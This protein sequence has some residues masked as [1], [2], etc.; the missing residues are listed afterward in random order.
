M[1]QE[2][3]QLLSRG[4]FFAQES[5]FKSHVKELSIGDIRREYRRGVKL[6]PLLDWLVSMALPANAE[7]EELMRQLDVDVHAYVNDNLIVVVNK[8]WHALSIE[9]RHVPALDRL[10]DGMWALYIDTMT[11]P[12]EHTTPFTPN[13]ARADALESFRFTLWNHLLA[14][15]VARSTVSDDT[16]NTFR[17][18][19]SF[20]NTMLH[21]ARSVFESRALYE[22]LPIDT[23]FVGRS[24]W[25]TYLNLWG[26]PFSY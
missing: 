12:F 21:F 9:Y 14:I 15:D 11:H 23:P 24:L 18:R 16:R 4:A 8:L 22:P 2:E 7:E 20:L 5:R 1:Q 25:A 6:G 26:I 10:M 3:Q 19:T 13:K 17:Y